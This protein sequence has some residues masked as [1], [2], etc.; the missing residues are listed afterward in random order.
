MT[1]QELVSQHVSVVLVGHVI[2]SLLA[3]PQTVPYN[4]A[5]VGRLVRNII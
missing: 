2:S 4:I 1:A 5:S 3:L